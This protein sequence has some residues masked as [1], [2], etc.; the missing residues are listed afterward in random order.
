MH[1]YVADISVVEVLVE[2]SI[3]VLVE[4]SLSVVDVLEVFE[5]ACVVVKGSTNNVNNTIMN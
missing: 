3:E 5:D 2:S 4:S 1:T